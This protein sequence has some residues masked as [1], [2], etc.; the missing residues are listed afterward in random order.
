MAAAVTEPRQGVLPG[1]HRGMTSGMTS[2]MTMMSGSGRRRGG[3]P[4]APPRTGPAPGTVREAS[5]DARKVWRFPGNGARAIQAPA[6]SRLTMVAA[7]LAITLA[8]GSVP[9]HGWMLIAHPH[10][11]TLTAL[12]GAMALWC[13]WCAVGAVRPLFRGRFPAPSPVRHLWA[14][15]SAMALLHVVLVTGFPAGG[16]HHSAG[17]AHGGTQLGPVSGAGLMLAVV[18]L[19][20]AICFACAVALRDRP[21][22]TRH[23]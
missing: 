3:R 13:L 1:R 20:L 12:M 22:S 7:W 23:A 21:A 6:A 14:M 2:G 17:T 8:I 19:E 11:I 9:L 18:V 10:G 16:H 15:A 5:E 4:A